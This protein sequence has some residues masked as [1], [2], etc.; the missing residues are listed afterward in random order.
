MSYAA[1]VRA[2]H[3]P[4]ECVNVFCPEKQWCGG[5]DPDGAEDC[6]KNPWPCPHVK[7]LDAADTEENGRG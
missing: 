1:S 4:L 7:A 5:C 6:A 3:V 2:V